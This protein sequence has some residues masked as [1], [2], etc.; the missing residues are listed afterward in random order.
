MLSNNTARIPAIGAGFSS[1]ARRMGCIS[2]WQIVVVK[3]LVS[4]AGSLE[5]SR[6]CQSARVHLFET[7]SVVLKFWKLP[8]APHG[9][10]IYK[11]WWD[12]FGIAVVFCV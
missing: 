1:K 2:N 4:G 10:M 9:R 7:E 8:C 11:K 5:E 3:D 6:R 12:D